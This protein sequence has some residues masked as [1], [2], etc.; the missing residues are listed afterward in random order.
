[1]KSTSSWAAFTTGILGR[2]IARWGTKSHLGDRSPLLQS[3]AKPGEQQSAGEVIP[4]LKHPGGILCLKFAFTL[5]K[6]ALRQRL[7]VQS[8]PH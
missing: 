6:A 4:P 7:Q 1:M 3:M 2:V 8:G 5:N